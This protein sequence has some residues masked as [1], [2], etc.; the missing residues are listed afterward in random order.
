MGHSVAGEDGLHQAIRPPPV[1][2]HVIVTQGA[3]RGQQ[4]LPELCGSC[5]FG[6]IAAGLGFA[7]NLLQGLA[8]TPVV[9]A[10]GAVTRDEVLDQALAAVQLRGTNIIL[11]GAAA[12]TFLAAGPTAA[13][14]RRPT[15]ALA[16]TV[17]LAAV[18]CTTLQN[19]HI[20]GQIHTHIYTHIQGAIPL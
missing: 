2:L 1:Q 15:A 8:R 11:G 5:G 9:T 14:V 7:G 10:V 16:V 18:L 17:A 6:G 13:A 19:T 12:G 4:A 3:C 20:S